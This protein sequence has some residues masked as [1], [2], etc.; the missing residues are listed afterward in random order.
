MD[1]EMD[2]DPS[3]DEIQTV[4]LADKLVLGD[5]RVDLEQRFARQI[6]KFGTTPSVLA[7]ILQRRA[8]ARHIQAKVERI[9]DRSIDTITGPPGPLEGV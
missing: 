2:E 9:T 4:Y 7:A 1:L 3:M 5:R 6:E 8:N